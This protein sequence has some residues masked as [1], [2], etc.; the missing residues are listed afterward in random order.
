M[1]SDRV[2]RDGEMAVPFDGSVGDIVMQ[3]HT[4]SGGQ[5]VSAGG[6]GGGKG[7]SVSH[8]FG[9]SNDAVVRFRSG[10]AAHLQLEGEVMLAARIALA[11]ASLVAAV[12]LVAADPGKGR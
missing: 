10:G 3:A 7:V 11:G 12:A 1:G 6:T 8:F 9:N 4:R 2:D 5:V